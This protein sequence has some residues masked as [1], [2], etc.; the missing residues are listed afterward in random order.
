LPLS[1]ARIAAT[2]AAGAS[3]SSFVKVSDFHPFL[4][5]PV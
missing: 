5:S 2:E 1:G 3:T 4:T